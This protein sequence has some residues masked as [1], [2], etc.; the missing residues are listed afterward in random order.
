MTNTVEKMKENIQVLVIFAGSQ[1]KANIRKL[2][3]EIQRMEKI[4]IYF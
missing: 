1:I 2:E 3:N 4:K